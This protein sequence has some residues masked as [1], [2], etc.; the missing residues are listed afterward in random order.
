MK[1]RY[2]GLLVTIVTILIMITI[3]NMM[4]DAWSENEYRARQ[5]CINLRETQSEAYFEC[6]ENYNIGINGISDVE[7]F[8]NSLKVAYFM[9]SL[10]AIMFPYVFIMMFIAFY[11]NKEFFL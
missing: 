9:Y 8:D 5:E 2:I 10:L 3:Q 6:L 7:Y 1:R 11:K 4:Y